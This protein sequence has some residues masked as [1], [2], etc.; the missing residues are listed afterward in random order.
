MLRAMELIGILTFGISG[1]LVAVRKGYDA[2][3]VLGLALAT[4]LG[5]GIARDVILGD[6]PPRAFRDAA[7][8]VPPVVAAI[9]VVIAHRRLERVLARSFAVFD[10][11]GLGMFSVNGTLIALAD[12]VGF[13]PSVLMG[14]GTASGGGIIRDVLARD[15]VAVFQADTTLYT[16][17]AAAGASVIAVTW[18]ADV[19]TG[20]IGFGVAVGVALV[21]LLAI[22]F[23]ITGPMPRRPRA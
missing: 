22:R 5:G 7:Y 15:E 23:R 16:I 1:G 12:G 10:A 11:V 17:P 3:G 2:V 14:V 19:Y 21:R 13:A 4:A 6:T 8:M 18:R 20:S 9:A